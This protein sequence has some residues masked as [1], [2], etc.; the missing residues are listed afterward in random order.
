MFQSSYNLLGIISNILSSNDN[1]MIE[2]ALW[3]IGNIT[4]ENTEFKQQILK[5]TNLLQCFENLV[6]QPRISRHLLKTMCWV[7][8]NLAREGGINNQEIN[9]V[10]RVARAGVFT[11]DPQIMSDCLW[12]L[13]Y[14]TTTNDDELLDHISQN[15][16]II[17]L[18]E[19]LAST[20]L[21]IYVPALR[22]VGNILS[23]NDPQIVERCLW[24]GIIDRLVPLL[25]QS[26]S[27][28]IKEALWCFSNIT[29]GP[30]SQVEGFVMSDAFDRVFA[31]TDSRNIDL[32]KE[33]LFVLINA[34]TGSDLKIR[35]TI[36]EKT[37]ADIFPRFLKA[38]NF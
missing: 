21:S 19:C 3:F 22:V 20:D 33:S 14:I 26:N 2:Q 1:A 9:I 11:E 18:C 36:F 28:L 13:S 25:Y 15:D 31:L 32:R 7:N 34:V 10:L 29:A 6:K 24:N 35:A 8:S 16:M 17:R 38:L 5:G 27:N 30:V 37:R 12:T 4:G 23:T